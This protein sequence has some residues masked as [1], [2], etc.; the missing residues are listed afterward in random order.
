MAQPTVAERKAK[1]IE[2]LITI[3]AL[4]T[5]FLGFVV[6]KGGGGGAL[7]AYL[8]TFGVTFTMSAFFSYA[9]IQ[10][11]E[12]VN[13]RFRRFG[14]KLAF[15]GLAV[16]F[17]GLVSIGVADSIALGFPTASDSYFLGSTAVI[18]ALSFFGA[19]WLI[20]KVSELP[21]AP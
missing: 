3:G 14:V 12:R 13:T 17:G 2:N 18:F 8:T 15:L 21:D 6:D 7:L 5:V 16:S 19:Y 4:L 11:R 1:F 10:F 9:A 20:L